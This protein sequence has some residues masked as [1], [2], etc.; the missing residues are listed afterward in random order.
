MLKSSLRLVWR[1]L[2]HLTRIA[3]VCAA[4]IMF[5]GGALLLSLRY[6]ILPD[7]ERY[8]DYITVS[9]S[10]AV[11]QP[12]TIG[13]IEADWRGLRPHLLFTDVRILDKERRNQVAL[14]LQHVDGVVSWMSLFRARARLYSLELDKPDLLIRRD[15]KGFLHIAGA[16]LSKQP[17]DQNDLTDWLLNQSRIVVHDARITWLD[18]LRA[19]PALVFD[20][21]R[22]RIEN[23]GSHHRFAMLAM[24]P[25]ELSAQLDVR[26]DFSGESFEVLDAWHGQVYARLEYADV[27][28]WRTW[29]PLP[30]GFK[31]GRGALRGWLGI[32]GGKVNQLVAD[33]SL[34]DVRA[35]LA[36]GLAPLDV[37]TLRGRLGW[38]ESAQGVEVSTQKLSLQMS[39][40]LMLPPTDFYLRHADATD[41]EPASGE[42][43]ANVLE[44]ANLVS[45]TDAL[46]LDAYLAKQLAEF[47]PHGRITGLQAKWQ[48]APDKLKHYE[49]RA[50]FDQL[51]LNRVGTLPG[52]S[53]LS[54][55]V[56][57]SDVRGRL[58]LNTRK[59]KVDA[60]Q[61]MP[62][63]LAFD[64]FTGQGS[65]QTNKQGQLGVE[66]NNISA[67]NEDV[68]GTVF[69]SFQSLPGSPGLLDLN[70]ALTRA[71]VSHADRYIPLVA[72]DKQTHEWLRTALRD[73]QADEFRLRLHGDLNDFPF[74]ENRK[75][76]FRIQA[77]VRGGEVQYDPA[78]PGIT[79][80]IADLSIQGKRLEVNATSAAMQGMRL[81]K[82][83]VVVPDLTGSD[84]RL[85]IRGEVAGETARALD[86]IQSSPVH[87]YIDGFTDGMTAHGNGN[88]RLSVDMPLQGG[89]PAVVVGN[90]R[91]LDN[92]LNLGAGAPVLYKTNGELLFTE[93]S[94]RTKNAS[95][96]ILGG[97]ATL[98]VQSGANG[99][100]SVKAHG[101]ADMDALRK[102][103]PHPLFAYLHG[104]SDW[105]A[106][107]DSQKKQT[108]VLVTSDLSG[109]ASSLPAPFDKSA[110]EAIPL[111]FEMRSVMAQQEVLSLQYGRLLGARALRRKEN[112]VWVVK[113]GTVNFGGPGKWLNR[114]GV[115]ITGT[116]PRLSLS[117]W[118][119]L[120]GASGGASPFNIAGAELSI[121][122]LDAFG[123][124]INNLR[125]NAR[126]QDG[127]MIAQLGA[128]EINGEISWRSQ[129]KGRLVARMRNL[130]LGEESAQ[131]TIE[132]RNPVVAASV[133]DTDFP[134]LDLIVD[135]LAWK[136]KQLGKMELLAQQHGRDWLLERMRIT[137][138][139]GVLNADGKYHMAGDA[140]QTQV[141]FKLEIADAGKILARSGYPNSVKKGGGTLEGLFSWR[142]AP[143]DFNYAALDG[144]LNLD[145]DKG[146]FM[147]IDPGVG[148]LLGILSLQA[149]PKHITLDF[150]D[151]FSEGF[152]FDSITGTAQIKQGVL[153]TNDFKIDGSAA[154]VLMQGQI[155]LARETQNLNVAIR[156]T[157]GNTVSFLGALAINPAAGVGT[158]LIN[159]LLR[160]PLDKLASFEY[161]VTGTW[162]NPNVVKV[163]KQTNETNNKA[164]AP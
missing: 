163:K 115:W 11:G 74:P 88:L 110:S 121:Q 105:N 42:V 33:L 37:R 69:G 93:S 34:A 12:V 9:V 133:S 140:A 138:P 127:L 49:I 26:G 66:F 116:I 98:S 109:L 47:A 135:E 148:K 161:N 51:S 44:L 31:R 71:A 54:G 90:Y 58:S 126:N 18:E 59:L 134:A 57:G 80:V 43:R 46:P 60:P 72:L 146:Q 8:H 96:Q 6:W 75:G 92:E 155:D 79:N 119:P 63:A 91:F 132:Q 164:I 10:Q 45:M 128:K 67:A 68:A 123:H 17:P 136:D 35:Q 87:A 27:A 145:T 141:N 4:L 36:D 29:L 122:K 14:V 32:G 22:L 40:G 70:I 152:A 162:I 143:E 99:M 144:K 25:A 28:A 113:R 153:A 103:V 120:L 95:A 158:F 107:I 89:K 56:D 21:V 1:S 111:R 73:G 85:Q 30:A 3:L 157:I 61:I 156:P 15:V 151:V 19:S 83:S 118:G 100:V 20:Q 24:P 2:N 53:G 131:T 64:T 108:N 117:G 129:G 39:N 82:A 149:L 77:R 114:D 112:D 142:G 160:E 65:W 16:A 13:R 62:E 130:T 104:G 101:R 150:T 106:E 154:K 52:F 139:D 78:W 84:M 97:P 41:K 55:E 48:S 23:S 81:Q 5:A 125:I 86:F 76:E 38:R 159:K 147:K 94:M 50:R 124:G 7:I 137:N 102:I